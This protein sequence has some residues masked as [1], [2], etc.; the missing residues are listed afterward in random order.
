MNLFVEFALESRLDDVLI[1]SEFLGVVDVAADADRV[2]A[3]E[4]AFG[5]A[6]GAAGKQ[7]AT[8]VTNDDVRDDLFEAG[9]LFYNIAAPKRMVG[10]NVF[11][12]AIE[13]DGGESAGEEG[14]YA[15]G[16]DD[17]DVF[18]HG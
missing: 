18:V 17:E 3:V 8:G 10:E 13:F 5:L 15:S 6:I 12:A 2:F 1:W 7:I 11:E 16:W 14:R 9:I 4:T